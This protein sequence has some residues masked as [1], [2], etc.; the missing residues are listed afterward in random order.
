MAMKKKFLG[1]ALATMVAIPATSVYATGTTGTTQDTQK[2]ESE[3]NSENVTVPVT[4]TVTN[5]QGEAPQKIEVE[6]PSKMAFIVDENGD[7][8]ETTYKI[9]NKS[10]NVDLELSV[11]AFRGGLTSTDGTGN[12]IQLVSKTEMTSKKD[13][14]FRNQVSLLLSNNDANGNKEVDLGNYRSLN[15]ND[16]KL[17]QIGAG[18]NTLLKLTGQGGVKTITKSDKSDVD[19]K[20][21]EQKFDLVFSITKVAP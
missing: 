9:S 15:A 2:I 1:L 17:G 6:L 11:G 5:K 10:Q 19:S 16:K 3:A 12:G 7:V 18:Q 21:A 4:G 13:E 14:L 8:A 20:G